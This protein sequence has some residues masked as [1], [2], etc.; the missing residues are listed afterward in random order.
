MPGSEHPVGSSESL[1]VCGAWHPDGVACGGGDRRALL[2]AAADGC[3]IAGGGDGHHYQIHT[4][5]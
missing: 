5:R 1:P 2:L 3:G 4:Q